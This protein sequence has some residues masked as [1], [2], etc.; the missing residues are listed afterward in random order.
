MSLADELLADFEEAGDDVEEHEGDGQTM[1]L[2]DVDDVTMETHIVAKNSVRNIAKLRDSEELSEVMKKMEVYSKQKRKEAVAGPVEFDPEYQL[3]VQANNLTVEIDNEIN[4]IHKFTRDNYLK[5][6]PE[7]ESLISDP[8]QYVCT[9]KELGNNILDN[10]K[11]NAALQEILTSAT[12]MVVSV[13][14]STTQGSLL[15]DDEMKIVEEACDM[16]LELSEYKRRIHEYVESRM[17]YIAPNLSII[18]GASTAAKIMGV[19]G[20]LTNLSKM[21][22][23]NI[24]LLGSQKKILAG[25]SSTVM[26]PHQ[27]IL[28][29][30]DLIEKSPPDLKKKAARLVSG[31]CALAA[32]VDSCHES[33]D[34]SIGDQFRADIEGKLDKLQEPPPVKKAKALPAPIDQA[35]KK[36]GGRRARKMKERLGLT[37]MRKQANRMNFGEIE[38]D[39]YQEDLGFSLGTI[40]KSK[41][42]RIR[43][44]VVDSKTKARISKSLQQKIAKE[45][46]T[47]G[48]STTVKKQVSGTASSVA[49]TPL[50]GLEIVNPQAAEKRVQEANAK[51]FSSTASFVKVE[52][53]LW[54]K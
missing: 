26:Q 15:T 48:G 4:V 19:A 43:G 40:G 9:V 45:K 14:A 44:P 37:E 47:W 25:F 24:M 32:R 49:F 51:Y 42:G 17:T 41:T 10:S 50:Q 36:R 30:C 6:F 28:Y 13:T 31:K 46:Q 5:R 35:R 34:G 12:I 18:V 2:A 11:N 38:E 21:P 39:A 7:L 27:G 20:G 16:A 3:I 54:H 23:C 29:E 8:L 1:E 22:A 33:V 53:Q 52:K